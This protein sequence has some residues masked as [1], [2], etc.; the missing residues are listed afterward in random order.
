MSRERDEGGKYVEEVHPESVLE[1]FDQADVPVLT[2]NE[3]AEMMDTSRST[4]YYKLEDLVEN[5]EIRK[6][7]VGARAV[8]YFR[9]SDVR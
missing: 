7:K 8:V 6:K 1:A 5:G 9:L 4:A 2:A 3:I